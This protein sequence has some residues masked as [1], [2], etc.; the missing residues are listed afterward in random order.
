MNKSM[1]IKLVESLELPKNEYCILSGGALLLHGLR[2]Q[3]NDLDIEITEIGFELLKKKFKPILKDKEKKQ[4]KITD[5]IEC[6]IEPNIKDVDF[7]EGY[8][9]K[10]IISIYKYKKVLNRKKDQADIMN[11]ENFFNIK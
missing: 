3:T 1:F 11:I 10:S 8:P 9:C 5:D 4:Y 7:I 6:F 2:E